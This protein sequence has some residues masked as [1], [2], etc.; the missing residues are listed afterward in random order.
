MRP[1]KFNEASISL[2]IDGKEVAR[3]DMEPY[4]TKEHVWKK[5]EEKI[6]MDLYSAYYYTVFGFWWRFVNSFYPESENVG[7]EF[8]CEAK[9]KQIYDGVETMH[10]NVKAD[11]KDELFGNVARALLDNAEWLIYAMPVEPDDKEEKENLK[12]R[13]QKAINVTKNKFVYRG[14]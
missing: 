11:N 10:L 6:R 5:G 2:E 12:D 7:A 9:I 14:N 3:Y 4:W 8:P 1:S 13:I